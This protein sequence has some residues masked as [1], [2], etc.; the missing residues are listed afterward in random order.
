MKKSTLTKESLLESYRNL[1]ARA[2]SDID[3]I[4]LTAAA[5]AICAFGFRMNSTSVIVGAMV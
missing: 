4:F 1:E 5:A 2:E 3:Y